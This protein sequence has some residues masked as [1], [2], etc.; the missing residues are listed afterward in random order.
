MYV[1]TYKL[2]KISVSLYVRTNL[3]DVQTYSNIN[4]SNNNALQV[5]FWR[6][7]DGN[8]E[9]SAIMLNTEQKNWLA[10]RTK[11]VSSGSP[12]YTVQGAASIVRPNGR[13]KVRFFAD[14]GLFSMADKA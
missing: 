3:L 11:I 2:P 5:K 13:K 9:G 10:Y 8:Y 14:K 6:N 4:I 12:S 7:E 1:Y